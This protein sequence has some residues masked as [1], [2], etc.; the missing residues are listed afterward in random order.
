MPDWLEVARRELPQNCKSS[1]PPHHFQENEAVQTPPGACD[2]SHGA[3][4]SS[5]S[6]TPPHHFQENRGAEKPVA[7]EGVPG[8]PEDC[9][10]FVATTVERYSG[11]N[12]CVHCG[13]AGGAL[14]RVAIP[15]EWAPLEGLPMHSG[16]VNGFYAAV[17]KLPFPYAG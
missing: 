5:K 14:L 17:T 11:G 4:N 1:T 7:G 15:D 8:T 12:L 13:R 3:T 10:K 2:D 16:C 6:S 9:R